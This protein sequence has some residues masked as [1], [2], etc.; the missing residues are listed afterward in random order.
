MSTKIIR[1]KTHEEWLELRRSGIGSSEVATIVG[2]SP[3]QTPLQLW[4]LKTGRDTPEPENDAM[5][6]GH[7]CEDAVAQYWADTT[8]REIIK[9]SAVDYI[10]RDTDRPYLQVSPDRTY[11]VNPDGVRSGKNSE[12]NKGILECKTTNL[13]I[14]PDDLPKHW[15]CQVQYQLCVAGYTEGSI[16]WMGARYQFGH[17]DMQVVPDFCQWLLKQVE[18]FWEYNIK[19]DHEPEPVNVADVLT[20]YR[21]HTEGLSIEATPEVYDAYATLVN[22]REQMGQL[23]AQKDA[24]EEAIKTYMLGAESLTY[25]GDTLLTW[26]TS[27][28]AQKF[29]ATSFKAA[30]PDLYSQY[31]KEQAGT[32]RFVLKKK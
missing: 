12:M 7:W 4:R 14:D 24:A 2:L 6:R 27:K 29:D 8:G 30:H 23:D 17:L 16:A 11:W 21:Q 20:K 18:H 9:R 32:R 3:F 22:I 10:V 28:P 25:E 5:R 31:C 26:K 1:P 13:T 19:G 15:F